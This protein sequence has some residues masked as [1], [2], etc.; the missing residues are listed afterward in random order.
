MPVPVQ[1]QYDGIHQRMSI[2]LHLAFRSGLLTEELPVS[3]NLHN[4]PRF[5]SSLIIHETDHPEQSGSEQN[6]CIYC[7]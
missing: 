5:R 7:S 4:I 3:L 2:E 1:K 6:D